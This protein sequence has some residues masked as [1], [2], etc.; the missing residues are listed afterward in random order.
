MLVSQQWEPMR[1]VRVDPGEAIAANRANWDD[2]AAVHVSSQ[3]YGVD[4]YLTDPE[5]V[6][7]VAR[8]DIEL[9]APH[10]PPEGLTG[11]D[12]VHLQCHIGTDTLSLARYGARMTG[13][14]ISPAS[15]A[16]ARELAEHTGTAIRYVE[17]EVTAAAQAVGETFD[18]VYTSTG[19]LTW[20]ADLAGWGRAVADLLRPGGIL[21]LRDQHPFL[22]TLDDSTDPGDDGAGELRVGYRY[23][24]D[25]WAQTYD[26]QV[27]Y[28]DGDHTRIEN[29]RNYE[30]P[31]PLSEVVGSLLG[32]GLRLVEL[33][34]HRTLPWP[35][36]PQMRP[37]GTGYALPPEQRDL[38]PA[39]FSLV[40]QRTDRGI[41]SVTES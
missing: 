37:S 31:H 39:A 36:L 14:D 10:L 5:H 29:S 32:A 21:Y 16:A 23:F 30:W 22:A 20:I 12:V 7:D 18:V 40:A 25:G 33:G 1:P 38:V 35:A 8:E 28:T 34:E 11:L 19:V 9:L 2:R 41:P 17:A 6:S 3:A 13:V 4:R 27:T 24:G 15:L 26:E